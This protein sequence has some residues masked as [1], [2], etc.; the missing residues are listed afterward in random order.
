MSRTVQS[1]PLF[2]WLHLS[3]IHFGHGDDSHRWS[4]KRIIADLSSDVAGLLATAP[5][6]GADSLGKPDVIFVTGDIAFKGGVEEYAEA[7]IWLLQLAKDAG[8][9]RHDVF[10]IPGNHDLERTVFSDRQTYRLLDGMRGGRE[11]LDSALSDPIDRRTLTGRFRNYL[12]FASEFSP[13]CMNGLSEVEQWLFWSHRIQPRRDVNFR[14]HVLGLNTAILCND[15]KDPGKLQLGSRQTSPLIKPTPKGELVIVLSHHPVDHLADKLQEHVRIISAKANIHLSGHV[16]DPDTKR[17]ESGDGR[18]TVRI[19]AGAVHGEPGLLEQGYSFG[20]VYENEDRKLEVRVWPRKWSHKTQRFDWDQDLTPSESRF[21]THSLKCFLSNSPFAASNATSTPVLDPLEKSLGL[22]ARRTDWVVDTD[23][24]RE[25]LA[26]IGLNQPAHLVRGNVFLEDGTALTVSQQNPTEAW[27]STIVEEICTLARNRSSQ[28]P[29][30]ALLHGVC[31]VGK[32]VL[33]LRYIAAAQNNQV[34]VLL[35]CGSNRGASL[36]AAHRLFEEELR[37]INLLQPAA[38]VF[39]AIDGLDTACRVEAVRRREPRAERLLTPKVE[40]FRKAVSQI[41]PDRR[42]CLLFTSDDAPDWNSE[43]TWSQGWATKAFRSLIE[44]SQWNG[45]S[46][47]MRPPVS[48]RDVAVIGQILPINANGQLSGKYPFL[49]LPVFFDAVRDNKT[50]LVDLTTKRELLDQA[51]NRMRGLRER[52]HLYYKTIKKIDAF[53]DSLRTLDNHKLDGCVQLIEEELTGD[54]MYLFEISVTDDWP[55]DRLK[56]LHTLLIRESWRYSNSYALSNIVSILALLRQYELRNAAYAHCNLRNAQI[57][58][59][60]KIISST[61]HAVDFSGAKIQNASISSGEFYG[62][63]FTAT[64]FEKTI[65]DGKSR[66]VGCTPGKLV[67]EGVQFG[68]EV[69]F[70]E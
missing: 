10:V 23:F 62:A 37:T 20:G 5:N 36:D 54:W 64:C 51:S 13:A 4:Q 53:I 47:E 57:I 28:K 67:T 43:V 18:S 17:I 41:M 58:N 34:R 40:L 66:F 14:V 6:A 32:T 8:L 39:I 3:D 48:D 59:G 35:D 2:S 1:S 70:I 68:P 42:V 7:R 38:D 46:C 50:G 21:A 45:M 31:G 60:A 16:H 19:V 49:T 63:D 9:S 33:I 44:T 15:D 29:A 52:E 27:N 26:T 24:A 12:L 25:W 56:R 11:Q 22:G 30:V 55:I 69:Q 65:V 61:F